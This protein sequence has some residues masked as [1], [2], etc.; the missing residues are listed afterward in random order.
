MKA[1]HTAREVL[2]TFFP[3]HEWHSV[4]RASTDGIVFTLDCSCGT[5]GL[6]I[7]AAMIGPSGADLSHKKVLYGLRNALLAPKRRE[8]EPT[9]KVRVKK[10]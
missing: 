3:D 1:P 5:E 8:D 6:E 10:Q 9:K 2:A 4:R 7:I